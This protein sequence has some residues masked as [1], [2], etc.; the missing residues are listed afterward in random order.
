MTIIKL[1]FINVFESSFRHTNHSSERIKFINRNP[2]V[3]NRRAFRYDSDF[4]IFEKSVRKP[5]QN[6]VGEKAPEIRGVR[7][8]APW[9]PAGGEVSAGAATI[10]TCPAGARARAAHAGSLYNCAPVSVGPPPG[11]CAPQEDALGM[12]PCP[13]VQSGM[14][15][16]HRGGISRNVCPSTS[17]SFS[18]EFCSKCLFAKVFQVYNETFHCRR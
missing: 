4:E 9:P 6:P 10:N 16:S 18:F 15:A 11:A 14:Q 1:S 2:T 13:R 5:P 7:A 12:A 17:L 3:P 8:S